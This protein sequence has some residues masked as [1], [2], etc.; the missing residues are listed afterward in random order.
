MPRGRREHLPSGGALRAG[1][2]PER[3]R[4]VCAGRGIS[5]PFGLELDRPL[6]DPITG[7]RL[8]R[9][10][11]KPAKVVSRCP[12]F[13][14]T[15]QLGSRYVTWADDDR[16]VFAYLPRI[17]RRVLVAGIPPKLSGL[18]STRT[19]VHTC[20]CVF[21]QWEFTGLRRALRAAP[22]RTAPPCQ[23]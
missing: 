7:V 9:C 15:R 14:V 19:V 3:R 10:G 8:R 22:R 1:G 11:Q 13:C 16:G 18:V 6:P 2:D 17:H 5:P 12:S 21:A 4:A 20:N 23:A